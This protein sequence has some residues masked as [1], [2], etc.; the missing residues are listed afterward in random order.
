MQRVAAYRAQDGK[1]FEKPEEC[2]E[3]EFELTWVPL[4][5]EF[6]QSSFNKYTQGTTLSIARNVI[7]A[8][9]RFQEKRDP[10]PGLP[11]FPE[12][13]AEI[14]EEIEAM[15]HFSQRL[16]RLICLVL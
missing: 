2:L 4:I 13:P 7:V 3:Y 14:P 8:W 9:E 10:S 11:P 6:L 12:I 5:A 16:N 15:F 1:L